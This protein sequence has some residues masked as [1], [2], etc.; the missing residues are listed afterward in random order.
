MSLT[1]FLCVLN[2]LGAQGGALLS[3]LSAITVGQTMLGMV[4]EGVGQAISILDKTLEKAAKEV[5]DSVIGMDTVKLILTANAIS[6]QTKSAHV[7]VMGLK[8]ALE[9]AKKELM[10]VKNDL[11]EVKAVIRPPK[12]PPPSS[13]NASGSKGGDGSGSGGDGENGSGSSDDDK[14][15]SGSGSEGGDGVVV[16]VMITVRIRFVL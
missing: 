4:M 11:R 7:E 8:E 3:S 12:F 6:L 2:L 16:A 5:W 15:G 9:E 13:S 1:C 10:E 14:D